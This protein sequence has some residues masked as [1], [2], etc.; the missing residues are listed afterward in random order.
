MNNGGEFILRAVRKT[1]DVRWHVEFDSGPRRQKL[2][3]QDFDL[4]DAL[5][6]LEIEI[7]AWEARR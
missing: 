7:G 6:D 5:I 1:A 3:V 2:A 4:R